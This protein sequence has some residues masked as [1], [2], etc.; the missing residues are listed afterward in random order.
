MD[1]D[2]WHQR[3]QLNNVEFNQAQ[4]NKLMQRYLSN[5]KPG[6]R[7][8]VPLCGKSI[9]M[10]WLAGQG[11]KVVGVELSHVACQSFFNENKIP[12][13]T[14]TLNGITIFHSDS[15]TLIA[16]DF[17]KMDTA[18][19]EKVDGVYD[20]AALIALPSKLR[21]PYVKQI[22]AFLTDKASVFL[23]TTAYNQAE[24]QGPPF[25]IGADEVT[26]L[27]SH[28]FDILQLYDANIA[29]IPPHLLGKGLLRA[30]EQ[31]YVL[32]KKSKQGSV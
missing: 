14:N 11:C 22:H 2:Y 21:V 24:M 30:A 32:T 25:S 5:L 1:N 13:E 6:Y 12:V 7:I 23:I 17:F 10:I 31:V 26:A 4:P 3:W 15:I 28:N 29:E 18:L 27:F 20:R 9:D 19:F 16:G 8:L